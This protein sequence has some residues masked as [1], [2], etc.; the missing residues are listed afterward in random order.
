M[1]GQEVDMSQKINIHNEQFTYED[2]MPF[3]VIEISLK[4]DMDVS[5][6]DRLMHHWHSELE[7]CYCLYP[8]EHHYIDGIEYVS[9][10]GKLMIVNS[11]SIHHFRLEPFT[12]DHPVRIAILLM[13]QQEYLRERFP[14]VQQFCFSAEGATDPSLGELMEKLSHYSVNDDGISDRNPVRVLTG[15]RDVPKY[16]HIDHE[17]TDWERAQMEGLVL[18]ILATLVRDRLNQELQGGSA[19]GA[20]GQKMRDII[21][22]IEEHYSEPLTQEQ[23]ARQFHYSSSYFSALFSKNMSETFSRYLS[24]YR[25]RKARFDLLETDESIYSIAVRSGFS[26]SRRFINAFRD[27]YGITPLQ[28]RKAY[29]KQNETN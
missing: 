25:A 18:Q 19:S 6:V 14:S 20:N 23:V 5:M 12:E 13:V 22:F 8:G 17:L 11:G 9:E 3:Q 21:T 2:R 10:P 15:R 27:M 16:R 24:K 29:K 28:Y 4:P 7:I 1:V 26:D